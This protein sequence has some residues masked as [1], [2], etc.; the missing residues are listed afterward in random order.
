LL[1]FA[2]SFA[3][4]D[5]QASDP[6][7]VMSCETLLRVPRMVS[8]QFGSSPSSVMRLGEWHTFLQH[9]HAQGL[10]DVD[11]PDC[12]VIGMSLLSKLPLLD[13]ISLDVPVAAS[14]S[15]LAP[16][17]NFSSLH[18]VNLC[19]SVKDAGARLPAPLDPLAQ[20]IH[21]HT[22]LLQHL[23]LRVGQLSD[24]F[25]GLAHAGGRLQDLLLANLH[26]LPMNGSFADAAA[27]PTS[28]ALGFELILAAP[29]LMH[30]CELTLSGN[31][32]ELD[33][34]PCIPS[35][36]T[37]LLVPPLFPS[38]MK[39]EL[40]L[41]RLPH[42]RCTI[43]PDFTAPPASQQHNAAMLPLL[44]QLA[45]RCSQLTIEDDFWTDDDD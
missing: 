21:L 36:R 1:R 25:T 3:I 10:T 39:L 32:V 24:L 41:R 29:S 42:L 34:V 28:D 35:L 45:Q 16:L 17:V 30:L 18:T 9:P 4:V 2:S 33:C 27:E 13:S 12:D 19:G 23:T 40:L 26:M 43:R 5:H 20:C 44:T 31:A 6:N 37:L 15:Y 8:L 11:L 14:S 7:S 22:L 38:A